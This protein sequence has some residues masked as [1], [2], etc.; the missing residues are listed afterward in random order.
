[1]PRTE[2]TEEL[3]WAALLRLPDAVTWA[4]LASGLAALYVGLVHDRLDV[5]FA[6]LL[7]SFAFDLLDG[8]VA[9]LTGTARPFG[10]YFDCMV[11]TIVFLPVVSILTYRLGLTSLPLHLLFNTCGALRHARLL[12]YPVKRLG[13]PSTVAGVAYPV[14]YAASR[15][16]GFD[17]VVP[18]G[19]VMALHSVG[20][21][22]RANLRRLPFRPVAVDRSAIG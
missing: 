14:L 5:A 1:M 13:V 6:L 7:L 19:V 20:M 2:T 9:R 8:P 17:P 16:W 11:D 12:A 18:C 10:G 4:G 15:L 21:V 3:G 22:T